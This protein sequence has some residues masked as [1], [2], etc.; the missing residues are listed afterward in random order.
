MY[1]VTHEKL[2]KS[3]SAVEAARLTV[4]LEQL[5]LVAVVVVVVVVVVQK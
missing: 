2:E 4:V 1:R 5:G 3:K